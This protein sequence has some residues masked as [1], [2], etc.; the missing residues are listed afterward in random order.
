MFTGPNTK[1]GL[2]SGDYLIN[3]RIKTWHSNYNTAQGRGSQALTVPPSKAYKHEQRYP[4][5]IRQVSEGVK[6]KPSR[7]ARDCAFGGVTSVHPNGAF[8]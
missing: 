8:D 7:S 6:V 5:L 2:Y 4:C 1:R 3:S